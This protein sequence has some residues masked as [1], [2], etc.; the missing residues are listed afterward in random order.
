MIIYDIK[1]LFVFSALLF[2]LSSCKPVEIEKE[3]EGY[4]ICLGEFVTSDAA[5]LFKSKLDFQLWDKIN[6]QNEDDRKFYVLYGNYNSSFAAGLAAFELYRKS[7]IVNHKV[8]IKGKYVYDN[9]NNL[10]FVTRYQGRPSI[11]QYNMISKESKLFWSR[12]GRKVITLNHSDDK[13][14]IFFVTALGYG[15]QGSFPYVRDARIYRFLHTTEQVDELEELGTGLQLYTYWDIKD[16]FKINFTK[17]DS[18]NSGLLNQEILS[19]GTEGKLAPVKNR[20]FSISKDGFPKP[21]KIQPKLISNSLQK[22]IRLFQHEGQTYFYLR[23]S[24]DGSEILIGKFNGFLYDVRWSTDDKYL[25]LITRDQVINKSIIE[26]QHDLMIIDTNQKKLTRTFHG[27]FYQN[28]LVHGNFLFFDSRSSGESIIT[29]Y[30]FIND[31]IYDE[32][33]ITGGCGINNL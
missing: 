24:K 3:I 7:L 1:Y 18:V 25:F 29:I 17:P 19:Y 22:V 30:D 23:D 8:F 4:S 15:K 26:N 31:D 9:F 2:I 21:P 28:L 12:W 13:S 16:T 10:L 6:I 32:I 27:S 33:R 20:T 14:I 11:Y 5:D